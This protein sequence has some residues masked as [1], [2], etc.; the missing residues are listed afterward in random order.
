VIQ[1]SLPAWIERHGTAKVRPL[2]ERM[3]EHLKLQEFDEASETANEIL[4]L[5][6][7]DSKNTEH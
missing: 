5:I 7:A 6:E 2:V 3:E 1:A 4:A